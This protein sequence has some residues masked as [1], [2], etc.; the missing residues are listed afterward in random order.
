MST[1]STTDW[2]CGTRLGITLVAEAACLSFL[3]VICLLSYVGF[4]AFRNRHSSARLFIRSHLDLYFLGLLFFDL[5]QALGGVMDIRWVAMTG[6]SEGPYCKVQGVLEQFGDVGVALCSMAIAV[7]T[8]AEIVLRWKEPRG[9]KLPIIVLILYVIF[10]TLI[11]GVGYAAHRGSTYY[12]NTTYWCWIKPE[13]IAEG[14]GL[15]YAWMWLAAAISLFL[16]IP[17]FLTLRKIIVVERVDRWWQYRVVRPSKQIQTKTEFSPH[18]MLYESR[19][20]IAP[21]DFAELSAKVVPVGIVRIRGFVTTSPA[22]VPAVVFAGMVF[23]ASGFWNV[24]VYTL[25][26]PTLLRPSSAGG[27]E[28]TGDGRQ[29]FFYPDTEPVSMFQDQAIQAEGEMMWRGNSDVDLIPRNRRSA[30]EASTGSE[31][32]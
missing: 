16:Y 12:G 27:P 4:K 1:N 26:R 24:M 19:F 7:H 3:S 14:I 13:F 28:L 22:P 31:E 15:E 18:R 8:F 32:I 9:F 5:I 21:T 17:V 6:V 10:L 29:V 20:S 30:A 2:D 11:V 23:S 25:T